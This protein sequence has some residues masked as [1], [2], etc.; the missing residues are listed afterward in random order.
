MKEKLDGD[1]KYFCQYCGV[2]Q[3]AIKQLTIFDAPNILVLHLKRFEFGTKIDKFVAFGME[4]DLTPFMSRYG[5]YKQ[6]NMKVMYRLYAV[7]IHAGKYSNCGHYFSYVRTANDKWYLCN[8][9]SVRSS[10]VG[11]VLKQ[12][13]YMFFYQRCSKKSYHTY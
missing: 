10:S 4:L 12:C 8:D 13:G 6:R 7:L 11:N 1:N 3:N 2:K 9:A 5:R